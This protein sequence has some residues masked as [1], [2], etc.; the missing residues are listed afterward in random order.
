MFEEKKKKR[1]INNVT[2]IRKFKIGYN[3]FKTKKDNKNTK[4]DH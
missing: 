4:N 2:K 1:I 3:F